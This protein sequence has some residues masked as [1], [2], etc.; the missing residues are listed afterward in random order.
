M[1]IA[2]NT[3]NN[4]YEKIF[5]IHSLRSGMM[6]K[7]FLYEAQK[8]TTKFFDLFSASS[9]SRKAAERSG[10]ASPLNSSLQHIIFHAEY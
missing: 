4:L 3:V 5:S 7:S 1:R 10:R 2:N 6:E 8:V 9:S